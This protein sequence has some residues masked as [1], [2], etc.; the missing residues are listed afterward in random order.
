MP[1]RTAVHLRNHTFS[2]PYAKYAAP[3]HIRPAG[4]TIVIPKD[5]RSGEPIPLPFLTRRSLKVVVET[6]C[7]VM[8]TAEPSLPATRS[9][10]L[11]IIVK[12]ESSVS[13][14]VLLDRPFK[15]LSLRIRLGSRSSLQFITAVLEA[16]TGR[17]ETDVMILGMQS[18]VDQRTIILTRGNE[19]V[20][21]YST[22][23]HEAPSS[24]SQLLVR[25]AI[26]GSSAV[27][28][29]G[30]TKVPRGSTC[31]ETS[32]D[33]RALLLGKEARVEMLPSL[34]IDVSD[35]KASH[36]SAI[37]SIDEEQLFYCASRGMS[38]KDAVNLLTHGLLN[39]AL[40]GLPSAIFQQIN[41]HLHGSPTVI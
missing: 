36:A 10:A 27:R 16:G 2:H 33:C 4:S 7:D 39:S 18:H 41:H 28:H 38:K 30:K 17:M 32:I 6:G 29:E 3:A 22:I 35:V 26:G 19:N 11:E 20:N 34:E 8:F 5:T 1:S 31:S 25:G 37:S 15:D 12:D 9:N 40:E 21:I 24:S 13:L 14:L 23:S